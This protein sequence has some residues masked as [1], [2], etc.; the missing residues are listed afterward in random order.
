MSPHPRILAAHNA[1]LQAKQSSRHLVAYALIHLDGWPGW[2]ESRYAHHIFSTFGT[3]DLSNSSDNPTGCF[4]CSKR[5]IICD[6]AQPTCVKCQKK[7]IECSGPARIRFSD[8][9]ALRG[10]LKGCA[11]PVAGTSDIGT[12]Q[13]WQQA[14][15]RPQN[16]RWK[17]EQKVRA[18][19]KHTNCRTVPT[20]TET[21]T[22]AVTLSGTLDTSNTNARAEHRDAIVAPQGSDITRITGASR[23][24]HRASYSQPVVQASD[25]LDERLNQVIRRGKSD[26]V[27]LSTRQWIPTWIAPLSSETRML[28][29]HCK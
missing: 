21:G 27:L 23:R 12:E 8:G 14:A 6:G 1:F 16:I 11:I 3:L 20:A 29:S 2:Q 28:F 19:R 17:H 24:P 15:I 18:K 7:G 22:T 25:G 13:P 9:V 10:R 5:R 4:Q 26:Q